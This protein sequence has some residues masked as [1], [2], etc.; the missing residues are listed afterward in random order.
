MKLL[1]A[2]K[3]GVKIGG[4]G[5][6]RSRPAES[7]AV[8][9]VL[10]DRL[11]SAETVER[12]LGRVWCLIKGVICKD[13]GENHFP[14]TFLQ[15]AGIRRALEDG[16]WMISKDLVV[17]S[18][19]DGSK[20]LEE[21]DFNQIPI[22]IRVANLPLGMMDGGTGRILGDNGRVVGRVLRIKVIID[23]RKP[24]MRGLTVKVGPEEKEKWV[25]FSYEFLPDFCYT[26][27][28]I[29][30]TDK[31]C[32]IRLERGEVKQFSKSLRFIPEKKKGDVHD[33]RCGFGVLSGSQ[34]ENKGSGSKQIFGVRGDRWGP[35]GSGS[36]ALTW[37]KAKDSSNKNKR[38]ETPSLPKV[39]FE[40]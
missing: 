6:N 26:C 11:I 14:V 27:G 10:A 22:W 32:E 16:P 30:H 2:E 5:D 12:A 28:L 15:P 18:D 40:K 17:M 7:Q 19:F 35:T 3:E 36:D 34:W 1:E 29:G 8:G 4:A 21:M 38:D 24:L 25:S 37:R 13:L 39:P 31:Q 23:I 9:K 33:S 20:T